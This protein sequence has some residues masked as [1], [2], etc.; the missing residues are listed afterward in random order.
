[1]PVQ[2][3]TPVICSNCRTQYTAPFNNLING[4]DPAIKAAFLQGR[5]NISQCPQCGAINRPDMPILYYDLEK[6]LA[7]V[8]APG[9]L[10]LDKTIQE[11]MIG[12][13]TNNLVNSLP[14]D[15]IKFYLLNPKQFLSLE[16]MA[17]AILEADGITEEML[18]QQSA[19]A[20]LIQTFMQAPDEATLKEL[21]KTHDAQ[22]DYPFFETLTA[23]MQAAHMGGDQEQAQALYALRT[24]LA[25]WS[26]QG[27]K[28]VAE[29]DQKIG[30]MVLES[31]DELLEK[32]QAAAN[33]SEIEALVAAGHGLLDYSFFQKLTDK[34]DQ[35]TKSGDTKTGTALRELRAKI[36]EIKANHEEQS[37]AALE[38]SAN[39]L[40]EILQ[41][42]RP[43]QVI[44]EKLDQIDEAFFFIL[45]ANIEEA[46]RRG[47]KE[48]AQ[49][50]DMIGNLTMAKLQGV[51]LSAMESASEPP[52][53][54]PAEKPQIHIG[55]R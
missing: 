37:R 54:P 15:Q 50:L 35:A 49:A 21:V 20:K 43:D 38:K 19:Q 5:L 4:Q 1:M 52:A 16:S 28:A 45:S 36:L 13:L 30:L 25:R 39:L 34:I 31:Q 47:Q 18:E 7:L 32:L 2:Q 24:V 14:A 17:K 29:I 27:K 10:S 46:Q 23:Y 11:K 3:V 42:N 33:D 12:D 44:D 40:K 51:D 41:S 22:L 8:L 48:L 9:G 26:T 6:E 53:E 55:R